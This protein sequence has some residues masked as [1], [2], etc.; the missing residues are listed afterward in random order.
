MISDG[1]IV[2]TKYLL[3][4][5]ALIVYENFTSTDFLIKCLILCYIWNCGPNGAVFF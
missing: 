5:D 4:V 1:D 2:W 3:S